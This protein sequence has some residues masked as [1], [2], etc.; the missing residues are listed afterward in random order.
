MTLYLVRH[1]EAKSKD[2]DPQ[3]RLT[4]AGAREVEKMAAFLQPLG[5]RVDAIWHSGKA[6]SRQTAELMAAGFAAAEGITAHDGL[7]PNDPVAPVKEELERSGRSVLIAGH[8]PFLE[9]LASLLLTGDAD[10]RAFPLPCAGVLR[11]DNPGEGWVPQ[12][13]ITPAAVPDPSEP[14]PT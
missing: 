9:R 14:D 8:L 4:D 7:A 5:L 10:A 12:W 13:M 6:R 1:G 2:E 3:R 11:L